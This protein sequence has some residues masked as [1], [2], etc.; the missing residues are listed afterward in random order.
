MKAIEIREHV[1]KALELIEDAIKED[2]AHIQEY[3]GAK[4]DL[5]DASSSLSYCIND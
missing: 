3:I 5:M 1:E 4:R 2:P